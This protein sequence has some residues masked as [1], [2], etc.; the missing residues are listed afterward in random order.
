MPDP[1][2]SGVP[3]EDIGGFMR[4][5]RAS[6]LAQALTQQSMSPIEQPTTQGTHGIYVQPRVGIGEGIGKIA[7]ALLANKMSQ[8]AMQEQAQAYGQLRS[9]YGPAAGGGQP[10]GDGSTPAPVN[11]RNPQGLPA[12]VA[13]N[14]AMSDPK[15]YAQYLQGPEAAQLA[16]IAGQNPQQAASD[17][18]AK[19][20]AIEMRPGS[21][22]IIR[23]QW[24]TAP[25]VAKGE[26]YARLENGQLV[27]L[28]IGGHVANEAA[29]AG[30]TTAAQ[31]QNT[32]REIPIGGGATMLGYPP[33]PPALRQPTAQ[34]VAPQGPPTQN[35]PRG[36]LPPQAPAPS[37]SPIGAAWK[38]IPKLQIPNTPGQ[39]SDVFS[40]GNL[41]GESDKYLELSNKY[42]EEASL[43]NQQLQYNQQAAAA[44]P[45]AEVGPLSDWLTSNRA[46]LMQLGVPSSII[47]QS[48][49]VTPTLE[50]NKYLKN[51]A[52]QGAKQLYGARMTQ[53][54]VRLQTEEMSPSSS[55]TRDAISS[56]INQNN[57][58]AK[59]AIQRGQ[60]FRRYMAMGG[61]PTEFE[62][63]Y[64][65]SR[66]L[67]RFA[68][69]Q[70][71]PQDQL[72]R[73]M[74]R[75][76]QRPE[77]LPDFKAKYGFDPSY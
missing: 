63:W 6:A 32:P 77:L 3:P 36:T 39:S 22:N 71:I 24:V 76:Q 7:Q 23:G 37:V 27:A 47:P 68:T 11:P 69:I 56:L 55:M 28:P 19:Q 52:L 54:E 4:A 5:Q 18:L 13:M 67:S 40:A 1:F 59:Y 25:D 50:L 45:N 31:Q 75:L 34:P 57:I 51:A 60:D 20:S 66:P 38:N 14:L 49:T 46:K 16:R 48:G 42:G 9:A 8:R 62:N 17:A 44:L 12:D 10:Q 70:S 53:N 74:Q 64:S 21:T 43:A 35:V 72:G 15:A 41:K 2:P 65:S 33:T 29:L 58:Q 30:A 26:Q 61:K 73:A